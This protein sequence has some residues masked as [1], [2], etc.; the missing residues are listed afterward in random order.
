MCSPFQ[1]FVHNETIIQAITKYYKIT[2]ESNKK[3]PSPSRLI[4]E[5]TRINVKSIFVSNLAIQL[6]N[7]INKIYFKIVIYIY[8]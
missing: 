8:V 7:T 1:G 6:N 4:I 3:K 5:I 2:R